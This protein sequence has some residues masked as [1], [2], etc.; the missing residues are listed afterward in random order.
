MQRRLEMAYQLS[1][2][3]NGSSL[4]NMETE[5]GPRHGN[6]STSSISGIPALSKPKTPHG[7]GE[8]SKSSHMFISGSSTCENAT[9]L[10]RQSEIIAP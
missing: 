5:S 8:G 1:G 2:W 6:K 7:T 3:S 4:R 10:A 9:F